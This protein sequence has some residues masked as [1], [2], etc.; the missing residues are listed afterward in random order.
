MEDIGNMM[1][2]YIKDMNKLIDEEV[3]STRADDEEDDDDDDD[4]IEEVP[5]V[6]ETDEN[7][8]QEAR[9]DAIE[10]ENC[11][12]ESKTAADNALLDESKLLE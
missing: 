11:I 6:P 12:E 5:T 1:K 3:K 9:D 4:N 2:S 10:D 8:K 7:Q